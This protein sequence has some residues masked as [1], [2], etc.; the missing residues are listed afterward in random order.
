MPFLY[1]HEFSLV[2]LQVSPIVLILLNIVYHKTAL[3]TQK[4]IKEQ[5]KLRLLFYE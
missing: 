3:F 1:I 2:F 4:K 5:A